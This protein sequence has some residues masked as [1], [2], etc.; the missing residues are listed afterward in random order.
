MLG[1]VQMRLQAVDSTI[2]L[3]NYASVLLLLLIQPLYLKN[4]SKWSAFNLYELFHLLLFK[5][6]HLVRPV[7]F[8]LFPGEETH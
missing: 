5:K 1:L 8:P 7:V 6:Q 3:L 4:F 2:G